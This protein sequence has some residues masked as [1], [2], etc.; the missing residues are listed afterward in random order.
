MF[1][2]DGQN[3]E[4]IQQYRIRKRAKEDL[5]ISNFQIKRK[6][7]QHDASCVEHDVYVSKANALDKLNRRE[8]IP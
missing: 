2:E 8:G 1:S 4:A 7:W 5:Y 6:A 3:L